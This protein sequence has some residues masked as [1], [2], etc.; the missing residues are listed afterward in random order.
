MNTLAHSGIFWAGLIAGLVLIYFLPNPDR[1][2][3]EG[4][5]PGLAH[6]PLMR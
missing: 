5:E 3:P 2:H 4:R 1:D 6:L